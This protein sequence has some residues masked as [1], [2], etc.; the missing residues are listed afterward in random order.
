[1]GEKL[2][3]RQATR[4]GYVEIEPGMVFDGSFPKSNTRRGRLQGGGRICPTLMAGDSEIYVFEGV[5][6]DGIRS[7]QDSGQAGCD[8]EA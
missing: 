1:M 2:R 7:E 4:K 3:I 6:E 8:S 5:Y